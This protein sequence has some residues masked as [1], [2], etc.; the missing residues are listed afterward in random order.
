MK[1]LMKDEAR[2][3]CQSRSVK[4]AGDGY[5]YFDTPERHCIAIELP[6]KPYQLVELANTLLPYGESVPFQGALLWIR[7]WG[8]WN[9]LVER[10]GYRVL[11]LTRRL[12]G[13]AVSM[14]QAPGYLFDAEELVDLEVCLVQ[15]LLIGWDAFMVPQSGDYLVATSHD[16]TT[17]V[18][19]RT[20]QIHEKMRAEL[21]AW[22][23]R[24]D[25]EWY[26]KG[27]QIPAARS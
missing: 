2:A 21:Q 23:P 22:N 6:E 3:W 1:A 12:H 27:T 18:L 14:E 19:S 9:E 8:V 4:A 16:E 13:Q 15:P 25:K 24:E 7:E 20:L 17:C 10:V 5:L 11:E 26:F